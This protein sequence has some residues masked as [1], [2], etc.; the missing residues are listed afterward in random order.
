MV[1]AQMLE[2][3]RQDRPFLRD[4]ARMILRLNS[5]DSDRMPAV[6]DGMKGLDKYLSPLIE[7]RINNPKDDL[8]SVLAQGESS[9]IATRDES[10]ANATLLLS[11]GHTTTLNFICNGALALIQHPDQWDLLQQDP[12]AGW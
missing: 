2:L 5:G 8:L 10:V 4:L 12:L 6:A 1:I 11:A 9:G 7:E 3:P